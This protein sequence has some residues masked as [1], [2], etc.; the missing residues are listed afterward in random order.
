ML[1]AGIRG[2]HKRREPAFRSKVYCLRLP[3]V[4]KL[5][6]G[7]VE[8]TGKENDEISKFAAGFIVASRGGRV[9]VGLDKNVQ[10]DCIL[11]IVCRP[12]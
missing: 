4:A 10:L 2:D 3:G 12:R 7:S 11:F 5:E 8:K 9:K 6:L 1:D